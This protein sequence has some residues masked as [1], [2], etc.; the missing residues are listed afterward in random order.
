MTIDEIEYLNK[1]E[2]FALVALSG[3]CANPEETTTAKNRAEEAYEIAQ[4]MM[5]ERR[6]E[7]E[8]VESHG[9]PRLER[10]GC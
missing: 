5:M 10:L 7:R 6:G 4:C 8:T 9:I 1:L 2:S 3:L